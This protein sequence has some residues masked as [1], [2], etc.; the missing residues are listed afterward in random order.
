MSGDVQIMKREI[1]QR[2]RCTGEKEEKTLCKAVNG[3]ETQRK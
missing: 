2:I 3:T 1:N